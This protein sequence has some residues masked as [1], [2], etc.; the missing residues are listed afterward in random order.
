VL[1]RFGKPPLDG[2]A[3]LFDVAE[4]TLLGFPELDHY[5]ERGPAR[6]W[7]NLPDAGVGEPAPWPAVPGKRLFAYLRIESRHHEAALAALPRWAADGGVFPTRRRR[8]WNATP[9]RT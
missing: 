4:D 8:R 7:G 9:R 1:G 2:V 6:Y 3:Q 5:A